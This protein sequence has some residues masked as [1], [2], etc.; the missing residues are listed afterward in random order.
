MASNT[1]RRVALTK[2]ERDAIDW[3]ADPMRDYWNGE[4]QTAEPEQNTYE[5]PLRVTATGCEIVDDTEVLDDLRYRLLEQLPDMDPA[6]PHNS[7]EHMDFLRAV[8]AA[9]SA[10]AKI[11]AAFGAHD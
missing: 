5:E 1:Y 8:K 9:R 11:E 7:R 10:F 6:E 3:A 2:S 4:L